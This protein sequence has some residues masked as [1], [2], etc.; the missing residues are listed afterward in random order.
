MNDQKSVANRCILC[1][2]ITGNTIGD[3]SAQRYNGL[4]ELCELKHVQIESGDYC[5][6]DHITK[7]L[8]QFQR[9]IK[10]SD[11]EKIKTVIRNKPL[12]FLRDTHKGT[13]AILNQLGTN[14][15]FQR[16]KAE[17]HCSK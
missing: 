5:C 3:L 16:L 4:A 1:N 11:I 2:T 17:L 8:R 12:Y 13:A 7:D 9:S 14:N 15:E 6:E 10:P